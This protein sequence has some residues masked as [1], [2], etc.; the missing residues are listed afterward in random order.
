MECNE[1]YTYYSKLGIFGL[2]C[3]SCSYLTVLHEYNC[4]NCNN[5]TNTLF[6][7]TAVNVR[8]YYKDEA[9]DK[10]RLIND[11]KKGNTYLLPITLKIPENEY[12]K[13]ASPDSNSN[14]VPAMVSLFPPLP[15]VFKTV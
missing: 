3:P 13:S 4:L 5:N 6:T 14:V 10:I 11:I 1:F 8:K 2:E 7:P 15:V 9:S 12:M